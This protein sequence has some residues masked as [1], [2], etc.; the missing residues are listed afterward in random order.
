MTIFSNSYYQGREVSATQVA[1]YA[2]ALNTAI[3]GCPD[4]AA[5]GALL[6]GEIAA[7]TRPIINGIQD[8]IKENRAIRNLVL[9]Q[10]AIPLGTWTCYLGEL[11]KRPLPEIRAKLDEMRRELEEGKISGFPGTM[12]LFNKPTFVTFE[13]FYGAIFARAESEALA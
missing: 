12:F 1:T 4:P 5:R 3:G 11:T 7:V 2:Q 6:R 13:G 10:G 8:V 9:N